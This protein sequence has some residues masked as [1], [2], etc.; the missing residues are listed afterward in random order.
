MKNVYLNF[1][2]MEERH[3][4]DAVQSTRDLVLTFPMLPLLEGR[5]QCSPYSPNGSSDWL[6][7][8]ASDDRTDRETPTFPHAFSLGAANK[9]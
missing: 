1:Y 4:W 2:L 8:T 7:D 3:Q 6:G 5:H 9:V